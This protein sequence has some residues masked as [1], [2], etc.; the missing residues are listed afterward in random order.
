V[1]TAKELAEAASDLFEK[2][3]DENAQE[4]ARTQTQI[5]VLAKQIR[6]IIAHLNESM[7]QRKVDATPGMSGIWPKPPQAKG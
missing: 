2:M 7:K 1:Q 6:A 3:R 4:H 5:I